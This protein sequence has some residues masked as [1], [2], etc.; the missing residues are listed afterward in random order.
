MCGVCV[1]WWCVPALVA[2]PRVAVRVRRR[3]LRSA[4]ALASTS[5]AVTV[6][7]HA[8]AVLGRRIRKGGWV[9]LLA[10]LL[11]C[12][13]LQWSAPQAVTQPRPRAHTKTT[14]FRSSPG[15]RRCIRPPT[16]LPQFATPP[17]R[18]SLNST[19]TLPART[20][21]VR[22]L[23][24]ESCGFLSW[25]VGPRPTL[26]AAATAPK[27]APAPQ[28]GHATRETQRRRWAGG[29][30]HHLPFPHGRVVMGACSAG[31]SVV[32]CYCAQHKDRTFDSTFPTVPERR[33]THRD[34]CRNRG[35]V[36]RSGTPPPRR[37]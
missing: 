11:A 14:F 15:G 7:A 22:P 10:C 19:H 3:P 35:A 18:Q 25:E 8:D 24:E 37:P 5:C 16:P 6:H 36:A 23:T 1:W 4:L 9:V 33:G 13:L 30:F 26:P 21:L 12:L 32:P 29:V 27:T 28:P 20:A 2:G 34:H 17:A 31:C